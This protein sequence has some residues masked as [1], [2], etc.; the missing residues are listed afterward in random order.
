M[1]LRDSCGDTWSL[2]DG[3]KRLELFAALKSRE[4]SG[5]RYGRL[6]KDRPS[7]NQPLP[8]RQFQESRLDP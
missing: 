4:S 7:K 1:G 2:S 6:L 3:Q 8:H 5:G